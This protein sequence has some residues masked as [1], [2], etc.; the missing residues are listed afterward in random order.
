MQG[1]ELKVSDPTLLGQA[2]LEK[3]LTY[4]GND[5]TR[6]LLE[7][8]SAEY[9]LM[10]GERI[11]TSLSEGASPSEVMDATAKVYGD[12]LARAMV[13]AAADVLAKTECVAA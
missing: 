8:A 12:S 3:T 9:W 6:P 1:H 11:H 2:Y 10:H 7:A 13:R 5:P 4:L